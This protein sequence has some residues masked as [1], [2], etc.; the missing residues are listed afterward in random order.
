MRI[1]QSYIY[2]VVLFVTATKDLRNFFQ[3]KKIHPTHWRWHPLY[4]CTKKANKLS[5]KYTMAQ[6]HSFSRHPLKHPRCASKWWHQIKPLVIK[7][8]DAR[9][10]SQRVPWTNWYWPPV[11]T[12]SGS[13]AQTFF[14]QLL[15]FTTC[16]IYTSQFFKYPEHTSVFFEVF[17]AL[18][19]KV[20]RH[21]GKN[22]LN[23]P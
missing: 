13:T 20:G 1:H 6:V 3:W 8:G 12:F 18:S 23:N 17:F 19:D 10:S 4:T 7:S 16:W 21:L 22:G 15:V 5:Y 14:L 9:L 2:N 11:G